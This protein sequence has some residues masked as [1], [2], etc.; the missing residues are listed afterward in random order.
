MKKNVVII[1]A[2]DDSGAAAVKRVLDA[3]A[4]KYR[5]DLLAK[6]IG[7]DASDL[8]SAQMDRIIKICF[9]TD[10]VIIASTPSSIPERALALFLEKLTLGIR[11]TLK[12]YANVVPINSY[13]EDKTYDI[14]CVMD[15]AGG[16]YHGEKGIRRGKLGREAYDT[17]C[18][19]EIEI[20][21]VSRIAFELADTRSKKVL[22]VDKAELLSSSE[23]WR[24]AIHDVA[25]DYPDIVLDDA[26]TEDAARKLVS[27]PEDVD[28]IVTTNLFGD[29]LTAM[30]ARLSGGESYA[31]TCYLNDTTLGLYAPYASVDNLGLKGYANP[32]PSIMAAAYA[33][34]F[35]FEL[36]EE[37]AYVANAV[38][39]VINGKFRT[40]DIAGTEDI[41]CSAERITDEIIKLLR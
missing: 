10:A 11:N 19:S 2:Y 15:A 34:K 23:L 36:H 9:A 20:E 30:L 31:P 32:I 27:S 33:L 8:S 22:S 4:K 6:I 18:Y 1:Y 16:I 40:P 13:D 21:R 17:E 38:K 12:L 37:Y 28:T 3:V 35:S 29:I 14:L 26:S 7:I 39:G 25:S 24:T 5:Q 41:I